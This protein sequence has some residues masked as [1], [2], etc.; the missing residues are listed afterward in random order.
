M[1]CVDIVGSLIH[2]QTSVENRTDLLNECLLLSGELRLR[3]LYEPA[4]GHMSCQ[5]VGEVRGG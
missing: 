4:A 5:R 3:M 1:C 2:L